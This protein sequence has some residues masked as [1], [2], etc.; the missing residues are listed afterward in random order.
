[1]AVVDRFLRVDVLPERSVEHS[2]LEVVRRERV[3]RHDAVHV[4]FLDHPLHRKP[5]VMIE[6][7]G[8][9]HDP[10]HLAMLAL[11]TQELEQAVVVPRE[12]RLATA[13]LAE[14][15]LVGLDPSVGCDEPVGVHE[16]SFG[17]VLGPTEHHALAYAQVAILHDP[18]L[19][20]GAQDHR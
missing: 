5:R 8:R 18:N 17:A 20:V 15:E 4:A 1:M 16:N 12:G 6:R 2:R 3:A 14:R 10:H 9:A 7:E 19:A 13:A 11:V